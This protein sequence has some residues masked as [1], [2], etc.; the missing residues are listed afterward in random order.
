MQGG[1][2]VGS[3]LGIPLLVDSSWFFVLLWFSTINSLEW[4][5]NYPEWGTFLVWTTGLI[6]SLLLFGSVLLHELGHSVAA[7]WQG[8]RVNSILLFMFGGVA[9]IERESRTPNGAFQVAIAGPVVS[10]GLFAGLLL[11]A[12]SLPQGHPVAV[13]AANLSEI[14][15]VLAL[16]N[17]IPGLPLDGG[18]VLK[19]A[20]WQVTGNRQT[21][22]L[23]AARTGQIIGWLAIG[24]GLFVTLT[25]KGGFGGLWIA[26]IGWFCTQNAANYERLATL[27][28]ALLELTAGEAA[29]RDYRTIDAHLPL[30]Q[31][32]DEYL[33]RS[34]RP[35]YFA[36]SEGRYRGRVRVEDL[37][38]IER[39]RWETLSVGDLVEPLADLPTIEAK[40]PLATAIDLLETASLSRLIVL[41]PAGS[42]D[43]TLDR[44]DITRTVAARLKIPFAESDIRRLKE[45]SVYPPGLQL[46]AIARSL[47]DD[48]PPVTP[49]ATMG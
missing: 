13:M 26:L 43:G 46:A 18:Q 49:P 7:Q 25:T 23:W 32:V 12:G 28:K 39:S 31:F 37:Q 2:R 40:T 20:V 15:L 5:Q 41:S 27:Q 19:A 44:G 35:V 33:L 10:L 24:L 38:V 22:V 45:E 29:G 30:R 48:L 6:T 17:L 34:D 21:G 1:W 3:V 8:I 42:I 36:A 4:G 11:L 14:N 9:S 16:F 47:A